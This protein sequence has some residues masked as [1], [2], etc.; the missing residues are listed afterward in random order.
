M[1]SIY[2]LKSKRNGKRYIGFT[3]KSIEERLD[4][5]NSGSNAWTRQNKPFEL[6]YSELYKDEKA[7]LK[8]EKFLKSGQG[9]QFLNSSLP[10][11]SVGRAAGCVQSAA[12]S[13]NAGVKKRANSGKPKACKS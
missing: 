3:S 9:R 13:G 10:C 11:S 8:R 2:V 7:A 4:E 6:I 5:H 12:F 1:F